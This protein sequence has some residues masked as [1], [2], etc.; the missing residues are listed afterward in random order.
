MTAYSST[1]VCFTSSM[2]FSF[3]AVFFVYFSDAPV[4]RVSEPIEMKCVAGS[5]FDRECNVCRCTADGNHATCTI[6]RCEKDYELDGE[7][8]PTGG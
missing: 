1:S 8:H 4:S 6:K 5:V 3:V 2:M 7:V